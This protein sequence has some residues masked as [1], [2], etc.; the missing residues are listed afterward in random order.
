MPTSNNSK[1]LKAPTT[2]NGAIDHRYKYPQIVKSDGSR[3]MR[4]NI[5]KTSSKK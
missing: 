4:T 5:V 1:S 3:D 2:K